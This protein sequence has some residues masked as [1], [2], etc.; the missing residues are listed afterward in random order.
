MYVIKY[1]MNGATQTLYF[2]GNLKSLLKR[3]KQLQREGAIIIS[4]QEGKTDDKR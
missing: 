1:N 3:V 4:G 2:K